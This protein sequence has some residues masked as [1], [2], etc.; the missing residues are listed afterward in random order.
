MDELAG[1]HVEVVGGGGGGGDLEASEQGAVAIV[2]EAG[3]DA[4]AGT[5]GHRI[6]VLG[7]DHGE[8]ELPG[9]AG[10]GGGRVEL[11]LARSEA[12]REEGGEVE[13]AAGAHGRPVVQ[14]ELLRGGVG[15]VLAGDPEA[16]PELVEG[17]EAGGEPL[18]EHRIKDLKDDKD[19]SDIGAGVA[20]DEGD[21]GAV[22]AG[23][24]VGDLDSVEGG[25]VGGKDFDH[26]GSR[27]KRRMGRAPCTGW[28]AMAVRR[29]GSPVVAVVGASRTIGF[30]S[31]S[32]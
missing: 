24:Q 32:V 3:E 25:E 17:R 15:V 20:E 9:E 8:A 5:G 29:V 11:D 28:L 19:I 14:L 16:G 1:G 13:G 18:T 6:G 7:G 31:L 27:K 2:A 22:L 21:H 4:R 30:T 23:F 10:G 12:I 26:W